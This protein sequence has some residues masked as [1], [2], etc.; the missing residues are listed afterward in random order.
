MQPSQRLDPALPD[1]RALLALQT[2]PSAL[3]HLDLRL[4]RF[5]DSSPQ[6]LRAN[7]ADDEPGGEEGESPEAE[8]EG[9]GADGREGREGVEAVGDRLGL[10]KGASRTSVQRR[11]RTMQRVKTQDRT[12]RGLSRTQQTTN[13]NDVGRFRDERADDK[14]EEEVV[15]LE[16]GDEEQ[17]EGES[18]PE[19]LVC[20]VVHSPRAVELDLNDR[21]PDPP[22][23]LQAKHDEEGDPGTALERDARPVE[24]ETEEVSADDG[25]DGREEGAEGAR[26]GREVQ[27][28]VGAIE[29]FGKDGLHDERDDE[30]ELCE[31][32]GSALSATMGAG[33]AKRVRNTPAW[34]RRVSRSP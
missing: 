17:V 12:H 22:R 24:P 33:Q 7:L 19:S 27:G 6:V 9:G 25:D 16:S 26:A 30:K 1:N 3:Q 13:P 2:R 32:M 31:E 34:K 28:E 14:V 11:G 15:E 8:I 20:P 23:S 4:L 21:R 10:R 18:A 5:L 29:A